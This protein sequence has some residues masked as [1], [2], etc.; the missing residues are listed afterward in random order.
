MSRAILVLVL[1]AF[2]LVFAIY[3]IASAIDAYQRS[4]VSAA[5]QETMP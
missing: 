2:A 3:A 4:C 5:H 1:A